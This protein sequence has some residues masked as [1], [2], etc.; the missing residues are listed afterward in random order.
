MKIGKTCSVHY[1]IEFSKSMHNN[2]IKLMLSKKGTKFKNISQNFHKTSTF[3]NTF[4]N[5]KFGM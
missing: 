2:K 4:Y 3:R 5:K 1:E